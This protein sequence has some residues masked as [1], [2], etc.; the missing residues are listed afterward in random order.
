MI[1]VSASYLYLLSSI[2]SFCES[3]QFEPSRYNWTLY[4]SASFSR[5]H[6][7][8]LICDCHLSWLSQWL[9]Q[10]PTLGLFTQCSSP[11]QLRGINVAEI[12]KQE[13]SCSGNLSFCIPDVVQTHANPPGL[14]LITAIQ[15]VCSTLIIKH[16][17][18]DNRWLFKKKF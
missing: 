6:S 10:R 7:N 4:N 3:G 17:H 13:F 12:Q 15:C 16:S 5:L 2:K 14:I 18:I 1:H 9:R 8:N 11:P